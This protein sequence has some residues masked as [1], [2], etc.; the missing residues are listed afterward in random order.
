LG[1][2]INKDDA[3]KTR[4][5]AEAKYYGEFAPQKHLFEEYGVAIQSDYE[6]AI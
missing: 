5:S 1:Y 4:L 2:F 6:V 3:I